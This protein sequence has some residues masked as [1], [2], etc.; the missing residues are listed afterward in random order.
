[1]QRM[2]SNARGVGKGIPVMINKVTALWVILLCFAAG[3]AS[4][5]VVSNTF[6][7]GTTEGWVS[8]GSA[9]LSSSVEAAHGGSA[10]LK[11]M[12][13]TDTWNGPSLDLRTRI[14]ANTTYQI[15][16]WVRLVA[17]QPASNLKFTVEQLA[18]GSTSSSFT[19]VSAAQSVTDAGWVRIQGNYSVASTDNATLL[20][21]L[22]SDDPTSAYYLDDFTITAQVGA[23]C[24][25]P[26]DQSGLATNFEDGTT[27]GWGPRGDAVLTNTADA[28]HDGAL[29]L[30]VTNRA[31]SW[32]GPTISV[33]CKMHKGSQYLVS[34]WV[35]LLPGQAASLMRVSLQADLNG[36]PSFLTVLGNQNVTD[37]DWVN[38]RGNYTLSADADQLQLYVE[39][40]STL[41]SFYIDEFSLTFNPPKP[42]QTNIPSLKNVVK[43]FPIGAAVLA[44]QTQGLQS[45]LLLKHF[46]SVVAGN[47][48]KWSSIHPSENTYNF[49]P[50]DTIANFARTNGMHMRG[51]TLLWHNQVSA[52]VFQDAAGNPLQPGNPE[53]RAL[54][55]ERLHSHI[56]TVVTRYGDVVDSWD[57]VNEVI[58]PAQPGGLRVTPWLQIIGPEYIDLAFQFAKEFSGTGKL[59][60]NDFNT[61]EPARLA[62]LKTVVQG[63]LSRGVPVDGVGHQTHINIEW[64]PLED[65]RKSIKTFDR[66]GLDNQ[67][68]ELD[69]SVYTNSTSTAPVTQAQLDLQGRRYRELFDL[70]RQLKHS[71]SS[72]TLWGLGDDSSWLKTFPITRDD[73]PL[74]FDEQ[75]QAKPAYWGVVH[76][77]K[78]N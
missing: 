57:V 34:V 31:A 76:S 65:I 18:N 7:D 45:Q 22:E 10:S 51:H 46:N 53:H 20:L 66:M 2:C 14:L 49:G 17:G 70:F 58:D 16:G 29:S 21:Y 6:E 47:D 55:I 52:W 50:A 35:R 25:E 69:M 37:A 27:Q 72:V 64:P 78:T 42:I 4:A 30:A 77:C 73:K 39:T 59:Y 9:I 32:Q 74:L 63:L 48:M 40:D 24:P 44:F 62:A 12:G 3:T 36:T 75:L 15:S 26:L 5:Q 11:T 43:Q 71:I 68:T 54:L 1:M 23:S 56:Q 41:A 38:F 67:I 60:I 61:N 13:R 19:Q 28:A 33:L 8:R